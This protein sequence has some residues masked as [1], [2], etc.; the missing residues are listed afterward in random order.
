MTRE[1][2]NEIQREYFRTYYQQNREKVLDRIKKLNEEARERKK[3][4]PSKTELEFYQRWNEQLNDKL[5]GDMQD[6]LRFMLKKQI[7]INNREID[8]I[9]E[10]NRQTDKEDR[11]TRV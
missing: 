6:W 7:E 10:V 9:N 4:P 3:L 11:E 5:N 8:K 2:R 1:Q